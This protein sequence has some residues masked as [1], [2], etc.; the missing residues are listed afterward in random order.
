MVPKVIETSDL[1]FMDTLTNIV[2]QR[3]LAKI[4]KKYV[5][6]EQQPKTSFDVICLSTTL[7]ICNKHAFERVKMI[8]FRNAMKIKWKK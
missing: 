1:F 6:N 5:W 3:Y 4:F 8:I 2:T 7:N